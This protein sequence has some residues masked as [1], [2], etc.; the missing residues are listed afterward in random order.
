METRNLPECLEKIRLSR[1]QGGTCW[2]H[3]VVNGFLF[4]PRGRRLLNTAFI[5]YTSKGGNFRPRYNYLSSCP[6]RN[7]IELSSFWRYVM[8]RLGKI[9]LFPGE[10]K[11]IRN[12]RRNITSGGSADDIVLMCQKV[13]GSIQFYR[14][15]VNELVNGI[16]NINRTKIGPS[17]VYYDYTYEPRYITR[18][19]EDDPSFILNH[20]YISI[21]DKVNNS[22][23]HAITGFTC[24]KC[25]RIKQRSNGT[26]KRV[27]V[28]C[29][30]PKKMKIIQK[31]VRYIYDSN[32]LHPRKLDWMNHQSVLNYVKNNYP[33]A[34]HPSIAYHCVYIKQE[35]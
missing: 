6:R 9:P 1:Q 3:S 26:T 33:T 14:G 30:N 32:D 27:K 31:S 13:F 18:H 7:Q 25:T 2:F 21:Q 35:I 17:P 19:P 15:R 24:T 34:Q 20:I 10:I 8:Y 16:K 29:A 22:F 28:S 23:G 12:L 5:A 4:T 11:S